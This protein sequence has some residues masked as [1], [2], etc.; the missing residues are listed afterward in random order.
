MASQRS[1][2]PAIISLQLLH[3]VTWHRQV[4]RVLMV[5]TARI[6][7]QIT[8]MTLDSNS[9]GMPVHMYALPPESLR[10]KRRQVKNACTKCQ[11]AC[12]KC[13]DARPCFRCVKYGIA[14]ECV[15]SQRKERKKGIQ[16]GPYK[17]RHGKGV[18]TF[19]VISSDHL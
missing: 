5:K 6:H 7:L 8:L 12:K 14:E 13:D 2:H 4:R 19:S 17:K 9:N 18:S 15:D 16:R 10:S 11:K 3:P 1:V